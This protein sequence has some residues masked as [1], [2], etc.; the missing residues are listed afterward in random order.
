[1]N[2]NQHLSSVRTLD[3]IKFFFLSLGVLES[4]IH[5]INVLYYSEEYIKKICPF[6]ILIAV[7]FSVK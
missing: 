5:T 4:E 7:K 2:K 3:A 1:M 6:Q